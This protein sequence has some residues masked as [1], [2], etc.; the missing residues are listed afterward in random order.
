MS[1]V[2]VE[3]YPEWDPVAY[4]KAQHTRALLEIRRQCYAFDYDQTSIDDF[5]ACVVTIDQVKAELATR[6]HIPNKAEAKEIR[7]K[8]AHDKRNR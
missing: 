1:L 8:K 3:T 6:E 2:I 7:R 4:L 5:G